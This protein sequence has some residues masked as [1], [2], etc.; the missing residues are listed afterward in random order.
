MNRSLFSML[1]ILALFSFCKIQL[2]FSDPT[3]QPSEINYSTQNNIIRLSKG[4]L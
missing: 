2:F 1:A 4:R 3:E